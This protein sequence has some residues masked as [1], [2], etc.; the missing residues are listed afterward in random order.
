M[1]VSYSMPATVPAVVRRSPSFA[2][3]G[4]IALAIR[5][6]GA[7]SMLLG[8]WVLARSL[9][10]AR[11]GEYAQA[12]AWLQ[13]LCVF[14]KLGLDNASLRY[15][16]EYVTKNDDAKLRGFVHASSRA[17]LKSSLIVTAI[18]SVIV[19]V[20][21]NAIGPSLATCLLIAAAMIPLL[22]MRQIQ[23]ARLRGL[24]RLIQS[25]I[26]VIVWPLSLFVLAG[27]VCVVVPTAMS[28]PLATLLHLL[29]IGLASLLVS[30][31]LRQTPLRS[32]SDHTDESCMRQWTDTAAAFLFAELLIALKSRICVAMAG[33]TLGPDSAGLYAAMERLA[34]VSL[35]GAQSLGFV[36]APQ[37]AALFAGGRFAEIQSLMRRGQLLGLAFTVPVAIAVAALGDYVMLLLGPGFQAGYPVLIALLS[38]TCI[39]AFAGP[40][41]YVLQMT[42]RERSMM[43]ITAAC[44]VSN[45]VISQVLMYRMGVLGLAIAQIVT[46]LIW[47]MGIQFTL[48]L[49]LAHQSTASLTSIASNSQLG[50]VPSC[51]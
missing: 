41:A 22:A 27:L 24:G 8:H 1:S 4:V 3:S 5:L 34:D 36:I 9:G 43:W 21:W 35:L 2:R 37:F 11:F 16:S 23:E 6:G 30:S 47:T 38:S 12:I 42:G 31:F 51:E 29:S 46:S 50:N 14:A 39:A 40:G 45:I 48:R 20:A 26:C 28:S 13:V 15:V 33:I 7:G 10:V 17:A 32:I 18:L 25:Q 49:H 44:A 19:L